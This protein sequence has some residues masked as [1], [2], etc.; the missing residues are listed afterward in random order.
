MPGSKDTTINKSK[1]SNINRAVVIGYKNAG[2][3]DKDTNIYN[4]QIFARG[5]CLYPM[6]IG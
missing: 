4:N 2:T 5:Q 1:Q 6:T 3:M